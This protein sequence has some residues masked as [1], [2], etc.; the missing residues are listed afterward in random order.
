MAANCGF[1]DQINVQNLT[2]PFS[3]GLGTFQIPTSS[4]ISYLAESFATD[5]Y[6]SSYTLDTVTLSIEGIFGKASD[7]QVQLFSSNTSQPGALLETLSGS[8]NPASA[9]DYTYTSSGTTLNASTTYWVVAS[10]LGDYSD[11]YYLN[12]TTSNQSITTG[13]ASWSIGND[14]SMESVNGSTWS[15]TGFGALQLSVTA[16][17]NVPDTAS[18]LT[19]LGGALAGLATLRRRFASKNS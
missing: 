19:L 13:G 5:A 2:Q 7:F 18:T 16:T 14:L 8:S 15:D 4:P 6:S 9:G 1:A 11:A 10:S 17:S 12:S 3:E